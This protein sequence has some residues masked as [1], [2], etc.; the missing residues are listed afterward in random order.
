MPQLTSVLRCPACGHERAE[1]MPVDACQ[2][3]Y[4]CTACG[5][6]LRPKPGDCCV[7]CSYGSAPCPSKQT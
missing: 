1:Q 4:E 6:M 3:F 5:R 7:Y 2:F